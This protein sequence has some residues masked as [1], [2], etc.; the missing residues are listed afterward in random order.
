MRTSSGEMIPAFLYLL[1]SDLASFPMK[2]SGNDVSWSKTARPWGE[3]KER[4]HTTEGGRGEQGG[5][6]S[7]RV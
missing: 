7:G 2:P 5:Q 3:D 1:S 4:I 6:L